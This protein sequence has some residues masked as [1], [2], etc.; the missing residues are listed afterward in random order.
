MGEQGFNASVT[1]RELPADAPCCSETFSALLSLSNDQ[2]PQSDAST[3]ATAPI[4]KVEMHTS[5]PANAPPGT[6]GLKHH[7]QTITAPNEVLGPG[8]SLE[9]LVSHE[10]KELG[11]HSL[12]C[13]VTYAV[14]A[15]GEGGLRTVSRSFRKVSHADLFPSAEADP[16]SV[17]RCTS[18]R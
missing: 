1:L 18:F 16:L 12:V 17:C 7:L 6:G 8:E 13:T 2:L 3:Q 14:Q 9:G 11:M 5:G 4:L 10:I 15:A